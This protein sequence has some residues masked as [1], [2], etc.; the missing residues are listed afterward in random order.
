[1][2]E[3]FGDCNKNSIAISRF[4]KIINQNKNLQCK[5]TMQRISKF[6]SDKIE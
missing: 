2:F 1:M 6:I 4:K 5:N 3:A